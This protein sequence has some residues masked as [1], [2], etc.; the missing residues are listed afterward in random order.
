[1]SKDIASF[2]A[3]QRELA[4]GQ[5]LVICGTGTTAASLTSPLVS[6][7]GLID[8]AIDR[9]VANG[10]RD[11]DWSRRAKEDVRS[12]YGNDIV[13]AAEK[14]T[15][16]LGGRT[17]AEFSA[18]L[19]DTVGQLK[20]SDSTLPDAIAA[21]GAAGAIIATT[22]YDDVLEE[23]SGLHPVTWR[24]EGRLRRVLK[25]EERAIVHIHG[26]W[27][28]PAS[29]VF[30]ASSYADV[31][32]DPAAQ[33][34]LR[35]ALYGQ[36][37]LFVGYG[38]GLDDPNFA[39]IRR[40]LRERAADGMQHYRLAL[41]SEQASLQAGHAHDSITVIAYGDSHSDLPDYIRAVASIGSGSVPFRGLDID[42][43]GDA[44]DAVVAPPRTS[45]H[46]DLPEATVDPD[47]LARL[48]ELSTLLDSVRARTHGS[49]ADLVAEGDED[50]EGLLAEEFAEEISA[51]QAAAEEG[52]R[53]RADRAE[54]ALRW[55]A[56]LA[57]IIAPMVL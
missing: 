48:K 51:V 45:G 16:A 10:V 23:A 47:D 14:A 26:H 34:F 36:T 2:N 27:S 38:A 39:S 52:D 55:A 19:T 12:P 40:W 35:A 33:Q 6:W 8:D 29:V 31:A 53:L 42:E 18:W 4:R 41:A 49:A 43:E 20:I 37:A 22:N 17:S 9:A 1:M 54:L 11:D 57:A 28:D 15:D 44:Q 5:L 46:V 13:A 3:L 7:T 24:Q 32:S 56:K 50:T 25:G 30:G 21:L